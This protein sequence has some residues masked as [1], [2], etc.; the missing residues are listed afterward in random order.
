MTSKPGVI[1]RQAQQ[2]E[3]QTDKAR[4]RPLRLVT[5]ILDDV[6]AGSLPNL[7]NHSKDKLKRLHLGAHSWQ[8]QCVGPTN[9]FS[10]LLQRILCNASPNRCPCTPRARLGQ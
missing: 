6:Y 3:V 10:Q 1:L 7:S 5:L 8:L 2:K 9:S 4:H